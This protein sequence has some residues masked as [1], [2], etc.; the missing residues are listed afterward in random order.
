MRNGEVN[1]KY[2][3]VFRMEMLG[4]VC[5]FNELDLTAVKLGVLWELNLC[6]M[7]YSNVEN[8]LICKFSIM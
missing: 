6:C 7:N 2:F 8:V 4:V 5:F 1:G 3:G